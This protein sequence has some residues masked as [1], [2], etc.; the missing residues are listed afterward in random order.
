MI[1]T[2]WNCQERD[3][4]DAIA[5]RSTHIIMNETVGNVEWIVLILA[6]CDRDSHLV[7]A[8]NDRAECG[9]VQVRIACKNLL[10]DQLVRHLS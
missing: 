2:F 8:Y 6:C 10:K 9:A 5:V 3:K 4:C 7:A 1:L